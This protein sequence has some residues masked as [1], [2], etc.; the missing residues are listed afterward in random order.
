MEY[1][2]LGEIR[3]GP[4]YYAVHL[5]GARVADVVVGEEGLWLSDTLYAAQEWLA[6]EERFGPNTR[7]LL[8]DADR[9]VSSKFKV[10]EQGFVGS[11]EF[12]D[13]VIRYKK[14][15][16]GLGGETLTQAE[17]E[18]KDIQNWTPIEFSPPSA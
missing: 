8:F 9:M 7:L 18:L 12:H 11:I 1:V 6:T 13:G 10:L 14:R 17:V 15:K 5:D 4:A 16:Y 3:F 2:L